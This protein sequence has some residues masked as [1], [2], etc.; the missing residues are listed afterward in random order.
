MEN[1]TLHL[2]YDKCIR[3]IDLENILSGFRLLHE[4]EL[5]RETGKAKRNFTD[6]IVID[7]VE[8]GSILID[9]T[10]NA[11]MV[12]GILDLIIGANVAKELPKIITAAGSALAKIISAV[13]HGV[14]ITIQDKNGFDLA[15]EKS[16]YDN[17]YITTK[18]GKVKYQVVISKP[19]NNNK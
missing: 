12:M 17:V 5:E 16:K 13:K 1:Y 3:S 4:E 9:L 7:K 19:E 15:I 2:E 18:D 6:S 10:V 14:K 8:K 11:D